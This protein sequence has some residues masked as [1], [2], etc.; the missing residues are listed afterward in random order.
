MNPIPIKTPAEIQAMREGG[1][2][3]KETLKIVS[4]AV[5]PGISTLELDQIA[6]RHI[7][8]H[9]GFG[10][11]F[12]GYEGF[13]G[14]LCISVNDE[15]VH[16]IPKADRI[17]KDGDIVGLDGGVLYK[18]LYTDACVTVGV[19]KASPEN[20]WFMKT[21]KKALENAIRVVKPGAFVGD[22]SAVIQKTLEDQ[23]FSP[24]I[25]CTGHGVGHELHEPP[26]ILNAGRRGTGSQLKSGM[27]LAI[28][29]ISAMGQ[30]KVFTLKDGW[31]IVTVDHSLSA[32][33]EHT[34]L[35]TENGHEIL[36]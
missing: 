20:T 31:T 24:V 17:L 4:E 13:P 11:A 36:A 7:R 28:E 2:L 26:E 12:K 6:E 22:I 9:A 35:V 1:R 30:G 27:V 23:G 14:T 19:G 8:S 3:L 34:V 29:P 15:V 5:K 32:H 25:A 10:P 16:G 21:T 33:Y 18:G